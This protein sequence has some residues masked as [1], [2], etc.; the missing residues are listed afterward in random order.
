MMG[1]VNGGDAANNAL[2]RD[3]YVGG[4]DTWIKL[5]DGEGLTVRGSNTTIHVEIPAEGFST[6][7]PVF[8]I[9]K[10]GFQSNHRL[11]I[12]VTAESSKMNKGVR[13]TL[14]RCSTGNSCQSSQ[15]DWIYDPNVIKID[16]LVSGEVGVIV[17]DPGLK[18]F[19]R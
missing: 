1:D 11:R 3:V 12:E 4:T 5:L 10:I 18:I 17:K 2:Q 15:I 6:S 9:K 13:Y 8:D 16:T 19:V 14:F 7:H